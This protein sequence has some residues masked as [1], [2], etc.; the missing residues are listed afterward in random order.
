MKYNLY[1]HQSIDSINALI[2]LQ[3]HTFPLVFSLP[4]TINLVE[5]FYCQ[6]N[7]TQCL[8]LIEKILHF[9]WGYITP[10][11][12]LEF[13]KLK[14]LSLIIELKQGSLDSAILSGYFAKRMLTGYHENIFLIES[15][16][17]LTLA[18]IG[19]MRIM[20]IESILHHLEYLTEQTMN[21]YG[22]LWYY[23]LVIDV[24]IELGYE[25][26]PMSMELLDN[27]TKYRKK[28]RSG[29]T[30]ETLL[31]V[32]SDCVLSQIYA[33]LGMLNPSKIHFHQ[34]L[35]QIKYEQMSLSSIDF[36]FKRILLK[37]V[38]IQLIHWYHS[39]DSEESIT[40]NH[41]LFHQ[42]NL[43]EFDPW[44]QSRICIYQAYYDRLINDY[45]RQENYPIDVSN[46]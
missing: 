4:C 44:N 21:C 16:I 22:K 39:K 40:I 20:N 23:I 12:R 38:E 30:E 1:G 11:E 32:Y 36:R 43:D 46:R 2:D 14:C 34:V 13:A 37:L 6:S 29:S 41:F 3:F 24:A 27:I 10:R 26:L 5:Y 18:L 19:E 28:L 17:H 9:W 42:F 8:I 15:C 45:R 31:L 33:R 25:L 35:Y 7:S